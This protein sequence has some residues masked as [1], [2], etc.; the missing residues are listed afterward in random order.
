MI[1]TNVKFTAEQAPCGRVVDGQRHQED[2]D[3]GLTLDDKTYACGCRRIRHIFHDGS[4]RMR[5]VRHDGKIISDEH[6]ADH[7]A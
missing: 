1:S 7:E 3:A 6:S 2:D 4:I 5:T